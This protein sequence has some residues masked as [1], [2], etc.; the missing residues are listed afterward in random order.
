MQ[1]IRFIFASFWLLIAASSY[2][3]DTAYIVAYVYDGDTV[4]LR[5]ADIEFKLRLADID[6]PERNQAYGKKSRRALAKLCKGNNI[7]VTAQI[8]GTDKYHR[9]LGRLQCN[10]IDAS[11]YLAEHGLA[12]HYAQYSSD[13][14]IYNAA[15]KARQQKRGL[16]KSKNPT[17][18]WVWR[19]SHPRRM[20]R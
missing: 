6:A 7:F 19:Q 1:C 13:V 20:C 14:S 17:P 5:N 9:S 2:A 4:K 8:V 10:H 12:W 11:T 18:P 3:A 15:L 16:W